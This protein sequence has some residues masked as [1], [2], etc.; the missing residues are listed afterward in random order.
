MSKAS[1]GTSTPAKQEDGLGLNLVR[2]CSDAI[3]IAVGKTLSEDFNHP[4]H[5]FR[6]TVH[7]A[8]NSHLHQSLKYLIPLL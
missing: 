6:T 2:V 8:P 4:A 1:S 3:S 7:P 5:V